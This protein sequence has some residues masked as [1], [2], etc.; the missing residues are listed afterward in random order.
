MEP[1]IRAITNCQVGYQINQQSVSLLAY[2]DDLAL[3]AE[4][5]DGLKKQLEAATAMA[6]W[7]G[8]KFNPKKCSSLHVLGHQ[9]TALPSKF[10]IQGQNMEICKTTDLYQHL[11]VPTGFS[12]QSTADNTIKKMTE[13]VIKIDNSLLAPWQKIDAVNTFIIPRL[14]FT[15]KCAYV[16]KKSLRE[17]DKT[18]KKHGKK[19]L[20]LPQRASVEPLY[21][22]YKDGGMNLLPLAL[23]VDISEVAHAIRL[24]TSNDNNIREAAQD[25][26]NTVIKKR[27]GRLPS[28]E[29]REQFLNGSMDGDFA[30][31]ATDIRSCWTNL[32]AASTRLKKMMDL[33]WHSTENGIAA[34][35]NTTVLTRTRCEF[36]LRDA[37]R[38]FY[39]K[40]LLNK[41][42]QGKVAQTTTMAPVSNFF[43]KDGSFTRFAE[44]RF[45]HRARLGVVPLNGCRRFGNGDKRCRRCNYSNETLPHVLNHCLGQHG[46]TMTKRHDAILNRLVKAISQQQSITKLDINKSVP[47]CDGQLRPDLVI[48]RE[49]EK[50]VVIIDVTVPFDNT[51]E[52]FEAARMEKKRKYAEIK[53][54]FEN[55]GF[56]VFCDAFI[57][58]SLG[59]YD[60]AN[61]GCLINARISRKY[62]T[63]MKKLMVSDTI[64]WSRDI[65]I[66][67]ITGQRQ[68]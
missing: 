66:E 37:A 5:L 34:T 61:I 19:W 25:A 6:N 2:A 7:S 52:A 65:Y 64:R 17:L 59:G 12:M 24:F 16:Q 63:L 54:H 28:A 22:A 39:K 50:E 31:G 32:R 40:K 29:E 33:S 68:Y 57:I 45:I 58:G 21:M 14:S 55:Q 56:K 51:Y 4:S 41:K 44:W 10:K 38:T 43:M 18:I 48:Q 53:T 46:R 42:D 49:E 67:H 30:R 62:S 13:D 27:I 60:P 26:I 8:L 1:M 3:V 15:L 9:F 36:T 47:G 20:N 35:V 11:G 23:L